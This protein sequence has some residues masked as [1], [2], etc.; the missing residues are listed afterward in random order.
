MLVTIH[1]KYHYVC[2]IQQSPSM[3]Y[4]CEFDSFSVTKQC[5]LASC[6]N[7]L[8]QHN[9][10]ESPYAL[11]SGSSYSPNIDLMILWG[12]KS[13][14]HIINHRKRNQTTLSI[15][16]FKICIKCKFIELECFVFVN[17]FCGVLGSSD[18]N[19][20]LYIYICLL[21]WYFLILHKHETLRSMSRLI[22]SESR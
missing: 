20:R 12:K 3:P 17:R 22:D 11:Y 9:K 1:L 19:K 13:F 8:K 4:S 5:H 14:I 18:S 16:I 2:V 15:V 21:H 10:T 7:Q 6:L